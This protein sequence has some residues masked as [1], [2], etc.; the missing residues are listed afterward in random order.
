MADDYLQNDSLQLIVE[1][2]CHI[3]CSHRAIGE[4][5]RQIPVTDTVHDK[6]D[7][8][9]LSILDLI[10]TIVQTMNRLYPDKQ[11]LCESVGAQQ[12]MIERKRQVKE[13]RWLT[14]L[15]VGFVSL[16]VFTGAAFTIMTYDQ[17][18]D[19]TGVFAKIYSI[20]T[21]EIPK[22]PGILEA[23]YAIGVAV[24]IL[25]FFNP[26][27]SSRKRKEPSP[28]EIEMEKYESDIQDTILKMNQRDNPGR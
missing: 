14:C 22:Q 25:I 16:T 12:I 28:I 7:R 18:V 10:G 13:K 1:D 27:T 26:F 6:N 21:G 19:V 17:D 3:Y 9:I 15:K 24:G 8:E 4:Y 20:M 11:I 2:V 5:V 23:G